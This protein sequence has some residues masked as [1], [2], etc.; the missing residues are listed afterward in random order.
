MKKIWL[1]F[2]NEYTFHVLRK[3]FLLAVL[4]VP[5]VGLL[6]IGAMLISVWIQYDPTPIAYIDRSGWLVNPAPP[7]YEYELFPPVEI[8][9]YEDED[10]ARQA[11]QNGQ[12][13]ACYI[14]AADYPQTGQV[15]LLAMQPPANNAELTFRQFIQTNLLIGQP[16]AVTRRLLTGNNMI[17][18]SLDKTR[19]FSLDNW[20]N[21]MLPI[22]SGILFILAINTSGS[23]L[24]QAVVEEK[25]NRT[26]EILVTSVS[27]GQ[28]MTGKI[29]GNLS[30]GLT[31]LLVWGLMAGIPLLLVGSLLPDQMLHVE[32]QYLALMMLTLIPSFIMVAALMAAIGATAAESREAQQI[33]AIFTLPISAPFWVV[34]AIITNPTGTL[35]TIL[36]FF[37]LTA[38][39][40]LPL[41]AGFA[42]LPAWEVTL[43]LGLL[44]LCAAGSLWLA[45]RAFRR[46][47]LRYGKSLSWRELFRHSS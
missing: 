34:T 38:P 13:Q 16:E 21:L 32:A 39:V 17:V 10:A 8:L 22:V 23:Y 5:L 15:R 45:A 46:G 35:A 20:L 43:N 4:S 28:L 1:I 42:T 36:S 33:A 9:R 12:I 47:M 19:Q 41:R 30:V 27:P 29:T 18:R 37:P 14:L 31:Q 2:A 40:T 25:E 11:L 6:A 7:S 3:R 44:F 26:M 24:L